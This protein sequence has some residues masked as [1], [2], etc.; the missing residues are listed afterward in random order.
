MRSYFSFHKLKLSCKNLPCL[1]TK[2]NTC[3]QKIKRYCR[4]PLLGTKLFGFAC[5]QTLWQ[6]I[7]H[8]LLLSE[9]KYKQIWLTTSAGTF[10]TRDTE[11]SIAII[12]IDLSF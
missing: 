7:H 5:A 9:M 12:Q 3:T 1:H 2:E 8:I 11:I 6:T 10:N 4:R